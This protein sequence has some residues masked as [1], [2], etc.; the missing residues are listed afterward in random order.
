MYDQLTGELTWH[1][2]MA[3]YEIIETENLGSAQQTNLDANFYRPDKQEAYYARRGAVRAKGGELRSY[4]PSIDAPG[5]ARRLAGLYDEDP[6]LNRPTDAD[7]LDFVSRYGLLSAGTEMPI[8]DVIYTSKYL[9]LFSVAID[10]ADKHRAR[11][12]F[13][14]RVLPT[15][16]VRLV[17][18]KTGRPTANWTLEPKPT[19]LI[20]AAWLQMAQELTHGKSLKKCAAPDCLEWFPERTNKRFCNNRCKMAFRNAQKHQQSD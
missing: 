5:L 7:V 19:D 16:T 11:Q 18:S 6:L 20:S 8:R 17:G 9:Y 3:G 12:L 14:E 4:K 1:V 10:S 15:I 13:N 2:D